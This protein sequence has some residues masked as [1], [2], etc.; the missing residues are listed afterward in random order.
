MFKVKMGVIQ[1]TY[2]ISSLF[3]I[4]GF[5]DAGNWQVSWESEKG[6]AISRCAKIFEDYQL[7]AVCMDNERKGYDKMQGS[8]GLPNTEAK[9]AKIRCARTFADFQLQAICMQNEKDGYDKMR[10]Y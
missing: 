6:A 4:T 2:I 5:A 9:K 3:L 1:Y 7:Q 10:K 8:F